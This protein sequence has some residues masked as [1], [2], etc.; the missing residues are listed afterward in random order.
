MISF[1]IT[2]TDPLLFIYDKLRNTD[3]CKIHK[4]IKIVINWKYA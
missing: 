3:L 1:L 2:S 4:L